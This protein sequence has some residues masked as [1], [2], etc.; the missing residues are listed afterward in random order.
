MTRT[1][2][3]TL[4]VAGVLAGLLTGCG[5]TQAGAAATVGNRRIS[6]A[7]VQSATTDV[8]TLFGPT[9]PVSQTMVL[10][11]LAAA[12]YVEDVAGRAG[13]GASDDDARRVF[14]TKVQHPSPAGLAVMRVNSSIEKLG[15][16]DQ[17]AGQQALS[18]VTRNLVRDH[19]KV[20]PRY[21]RFDP[22][23]GRLLPDQPNWLPTPSPAAS[24]E[25]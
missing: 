24:P 17:A 6:V 10:F 16:L 5:S 21:G 1:G 18:E 11:L 8:Q 13:V 20:N 3:R 15:Q 12:P 2:I 9:Q 14:G 4:L 23:R 19:L 7:D 22:Q 25:Q